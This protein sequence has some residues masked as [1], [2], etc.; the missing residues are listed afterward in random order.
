MGYKV[1]IGS[2]KQEDCHT[3]IDASDLETAKA[4]LHATAR[5]SRPELAIANIGDYRSWVGNDGLD[6]VDLSTDRHRAFRGLVEEILKKEEAA[7][8]LGEVFDNTYLPD[9]VIEPV[10]EGKARVSSIAMQF[11]S[12]TAWDRIQDLVKELIAEYQDLVA[13]GEVSKPVY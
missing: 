8:D 12:V 10:E 7:D 2:L 13:A 6:R 3:E 5:K 11:D 1:L 4:W 9:I